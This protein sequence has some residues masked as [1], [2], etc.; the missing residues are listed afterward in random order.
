MPFQGVWQTFQKGWS[1]TT[2]F[3]KSFSVYAW[4]INLILLESDSSRVMHSLVPWGGPVPQASQPINRSHWPPGNKEDDGLWRDSFFL[5]FL[6][7]SF[8]PSFL[9]WDSTVKCWVLFRDKDG[10]HKIGKWFKIKGCSFC[11]ACTLWWFL[12]KRC[13]IHY[14]RCTVVHRLFISQQPR[15]Q[16]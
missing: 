5:Y 12:H 8:F 9:W 16:K 6:S 4:L 15:L 14:H 1:W 10:V 13:W 11:R 7:P 3:L 2:F